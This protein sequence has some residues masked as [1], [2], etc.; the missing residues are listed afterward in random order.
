MA[1]LLEPKIVFIQMSPRGLEALSPDEP[2][3][4]SQPQPQAPKPVEIDPNP[5]F[6][7]V[8]NTPLLKMENPTVGV[9]EDP[10]NPDRA[11]KAGVATD[12]PEV[13]MA[14]RNEEKVRRIKRQPLLRGNM[15]LLEGL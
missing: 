6:N 3:Q 11:P 10:A 2:G 9:R 13:R 15:S 14:L 8:Q 1:G 4:E 12:T 5:V 7:P